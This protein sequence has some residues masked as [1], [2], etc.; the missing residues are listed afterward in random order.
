MRDSSLYIH[1][2][3]LLY[4]ETALTHSPALV[5][6]SSQIVLGSELEPERLTQNDTDFA[7]TLS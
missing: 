5:R 7:M 4:R 1:S 3:R 6:L 2:L